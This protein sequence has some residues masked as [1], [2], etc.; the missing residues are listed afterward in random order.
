LATTLAEELAPAGPLE[1]WREELGRGAVGFGTALAQLGRVLDA[2]LFEASFVVVA[3]L[4]ELF[5]AEVFDG[6]RAVFRAVLRRAD[7]G[8]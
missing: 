7:E 3:Q 6:Q 8:A 4:E 2:L 5:G 1:D